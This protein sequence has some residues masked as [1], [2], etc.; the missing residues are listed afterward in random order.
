[1]FWIKVVGAIVAHVAHTITVDIR[2]ISIG[3]ERT[4]VTHIAHAIAV[5]ILL[6]RIGHKRAI[7]V[8]VGH[9]V[10]VG[11]FKRWL[12]RRWRRRLATWLA[13]ALAFPAH[14]VDRAHVAV[15]ARLAVLVAI[16]LVAAA[17][18]IALA[19][20][21]FAILGRS[22][23]LVFVSVR[24]LA[25]VVRQHHAARFLA[26]HGRAKL[27]LLLCGAVAHSIALAVASLIKR[28][29]DVIGKHQV[30]A[31]HEHKKNYTK[32]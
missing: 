10:A 22:R 30:A 9:T 14:V 11:V 26:L 3:N 17:H 21:G 8:H 29:Y 28:L 25:V 16:L 6:Q 4:I 13:F 27:R 15:V 2:L 12:G 23:A 18:A 20:A 1:M 31:Q 19:V 32:K 5:A 7:V 24:P